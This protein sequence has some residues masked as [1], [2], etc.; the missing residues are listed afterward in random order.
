MERKTT[1]RCLEGIRENVCEEEG[2]GVDAVA[3]DESRAHAASECCVEVA[4]CEVDWA[5]LKLSLLLVLDIDAALW[6]Q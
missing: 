4:W 1:G 2:L 6:T 3:H 5:V